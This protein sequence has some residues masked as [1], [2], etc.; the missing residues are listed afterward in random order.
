MSRIAPLAVVA[1]LIAAALVLAAC[2]SDGDDQPGATST[3][4]LGEPTVVATPTPSSAVASSGTAIFRR[5]GSL[6]LAALDGSSAPRQLTENTV[7]VGVAGHVRRTGGATDLYYISQL[8]ED[9]VENEMTVSDQALFRVS[10]A[11]GDSE[12]LLRYTGRSLEA[13]L[14]AT[15]S[16]SPDGAYILYSDEQGISLLNVEVA[17]TRP[18]LTRSPPCLGP[19]GCFSYHR[20]LW[21]PDGTRA[22]IAKFVWEGG[23]DIIIDPFADVI[24]EQQT[25]GGA[26][27]TASWSPDSARIC[28]SEFTYASTGAAIAYDIATDE[29]VDTT[30]DLPLPTPEE[31]GRLRI[32]TRGCA[33]SDSGDLAVPY[34]RPDNYAE[35][36][37]AILDAD[38]QVIYESDVI[39]NFSVLAGW[40]PDGS[41]V[42]FNRWQQQEGRPLPPAIFDFERG[43]VEL[44]FEADQVLAVIS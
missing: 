27:F 39:A 42:V 11:G 33:W 24:E 36:W 12:E 43:I 38:Y 10:L 9:R 40:L 19:Q 20:P 4:P 15:A 30:L 21:S 6:W 28:I 32:D 17:D 37:I 35:V 41:G 44:P 14:G 25:H 31:E 34:M 26:S 23:S 1:A 5:D 29:A 8:S 2:S 3:V 18:V 13:F 22:S 7:N 16:V